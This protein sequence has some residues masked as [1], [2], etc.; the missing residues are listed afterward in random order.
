MANSIA[1]GLEQFCGLVGPAAAGFT[2]AWVSSSAMKADAET[3]SLYGVGVA[4]SLDA[5]A[6]SVSVMMLWL[7]ALPCQQS[8]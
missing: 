5:L 2:I 1:S 8:Q 4:L 3:L 7:I 6:T